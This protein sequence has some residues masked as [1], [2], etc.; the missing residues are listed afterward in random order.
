M[1]VEVVTWRA[2]AGWSAPLPEPDRRASL[3]L[4]FGDRTVAS[5]P[6]RPLAQVARQWRDHTVLGCSTA[7]QLVGGDLLDDALVV[8]VVRFD[9][10]RLVSGHVDITRTGGPRR[11]GRAIAELVG[12]PEC[13]GAFVLSDGLAV[14][15]SSLVAGIADVLP[16]LPVSG[17]LAGDGDRFG[18]T[19]TLVGGE[20]RPHHVSVVGFVGDIELGHGSVGGWDIFGPERVVTR[21]HGNVLYE[22]DARG[23]LDLY[24]EY[25]GPLADGLPATGLLFPLLVRDLDDREVVRTVLAVDE[26]TGSLTFA[27]DVPQGST[28]QLMRASTDHLVHGAHLAAKAAATGHERLALAVSCVGR[29]LVMGER[30]EEELDAVLEAFAP[31]TVLTGFYSYGEWSPT[32][33]RNDL[34]NQTMTVTT[35]AER[36]VVTPRPADGSTR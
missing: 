1:D 3:V 23:A 5:H 18:E 16:G 29:R 26:R 10:A 27:G 12:H 8:T 22:I 33:G 24:R 7:G 9:H 35:V 34:H 32:D 13:R 25:L 15:G 6:D 36:P 31:D 20:P 4:A 30:T 28:A 11:A 19:W 21:S 14:N 17:G 2:T